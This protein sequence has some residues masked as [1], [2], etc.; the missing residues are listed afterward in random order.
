MILTINLAE[1]VHVL[2]TYCRFKYLLLAGTRKLHLHWFWLLFCNGELTGSNDS[3][4]Y[5]VWNWRCWEGQV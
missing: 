1:E 3:V 4:L 5:H 2:L